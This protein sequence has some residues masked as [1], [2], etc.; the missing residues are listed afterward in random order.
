MTPPVIQA[1]L[2]GQ[3]C[4]RPTIPATRPPRLPPPTPLLSILPSP[5]PR[6]PPGPQPPRPP[7]PQP[8]STPPPCASPSP[9][10]ATCVCGSRATARSTAGPPPGSRCRAEVGWGWG[11]G[12]R[13]QRPGVRSSNARRSD[14]V[15][16]WTAQAGRAGR[17]ATSKHRLR[18]QHR[19]GGKGARQH[20]TGVP[21]KGSTG[22]WRSCTAH[23]QAARCRA[24]RQWMAPR[25]RRYSPWHSR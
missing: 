17:R 15:S 20:G 8:P 16:G 9:A 4:C 13:R 21:S 19:Q 3:A 14:H 12:G 11:L 1:L 25:N 10:S 6:P 7:G 2:D 5:S 22:G 23:L 18:L 24:A